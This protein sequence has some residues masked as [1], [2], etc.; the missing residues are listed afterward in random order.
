MSLL[1]ESLAVIPNANSREMM[2]QKQ[3]ALLLS[4]GALHL[5]KALSNK[6]ATA[7]AHAAAAD[8]SEGTCALQY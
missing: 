5:R 2:S 8:T 3:K 7:G 4:T 1:R 6:S